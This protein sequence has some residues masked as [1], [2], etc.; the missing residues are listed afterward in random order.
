MNKI[1]DSMM[2]GKPLLYAVNAPNNYVKR[3]QCGI[4]IEPGNVDALTRGIQELKDMSENDRIKMG[5]KGKQAVVENYNYKVLAKRF[6]EL[7]VK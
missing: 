2:G 5:K 6:E 3:Y 1:Y 7:L 4:D